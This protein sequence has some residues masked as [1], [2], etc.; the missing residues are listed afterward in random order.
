MAIYAISDLHLALSTPKPMD[1]FGEGWTRYMDR[2]EEAWR[3]V[4]QPEDHVLIPG[5]LSWATYLEAAD[6]DFDFLEALP[7]RKVI[8]KGN[9]DYW[10]TTMRKMQAYLER[11]RL[12]T[13]SFLFND[14]IRIGTVAVAAAR[15]WLCP[16]MPDY[17][18]VEDEKIYL[19]E[20]GR[21]QLSLAALEKQQQ[22]YDK[23][24]VMLHF[25]PF[26]NKV[27]QTA[28]TEILEACHPDICLYGHLHGPAAQYAY[29]GK[30]GGTEFIMV[31]ADHLQFHPLRI[32]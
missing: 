18:A 30:L 12:E 25:P 28:F 5:D 27:Q 20:I 2:T 24:I 29:Q 19:R 6:A 8:S 26:S 10:W 31:A 32:D 16:G 3:A 15:G 13:I 14:V 23:L 7:G 21:L 11:R 9:H 4:V 1:I 17:K 22:P